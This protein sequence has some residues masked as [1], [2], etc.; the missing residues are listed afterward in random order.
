MFARRAVCCYSNVTSTKVEQLIN[1]KFLVKLKK[2]PT[3]CLKLLEKV[4]GEDVMSR[5]Q[6]FEWHKCFKNGREK[7]EDDPNSG[8][9]STSKTDDNIARVKQLVRNDRRLTVRMFGEGLGLNRESV[10]KILL[11]DLGMPKMCAKMVPKILSKN[12]K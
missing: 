8:L 4:Y 5:T 2:T 11:D 12:Q 6:I 10:R 3:E 9:P 1:L 7:V